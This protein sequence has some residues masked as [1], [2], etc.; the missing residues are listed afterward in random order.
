MQGAVAQLSHW[1]PG[2][3]S[4]QKGLW[5]NREWCQIV[6]PMHVLSISFQRKAP[7]IFGRP[8]FDLWME[9]RLHEVA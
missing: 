5:W 1:E 7:L 8:Y 3:P 6:V 2:G 9:K 4:D